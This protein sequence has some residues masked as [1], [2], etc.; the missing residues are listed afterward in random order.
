MHPVARAP[1]LVSALLLLAVA[2]HAPSLTAVAAQAASPSPNASHSGP[3]FALAFRS[4]LLGFGLEANKLIVGHLGARVGFSYFKFNANHTQS[5]ITYSASIKVSSFQALADIYPASRKSF[6]LTGGIITNPLTV[7]GTGLTTSGS[8]KINGHSYTAD[9]VGTLS[10]AGKFPSVSPYV[11]LG[12]GTPARGNGSHLA[13]LFDIGA[14]LGQPTISLAATGAATNE[15]LAS[16]LQ[17][18]TATTQHDVRK[19]AK[20]FPVL[21]FGIGYRF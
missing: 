1:K 20:V 12:F 5:D 2:G 8:F 14:A 4:S 3:D 7:S 9:E 11:G 15:Q 16:D 6:H 21:S 10:A 13:F 18:Q 17:A 19:Y